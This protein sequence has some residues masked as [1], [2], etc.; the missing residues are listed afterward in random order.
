MA[1][2]LNPITSGASGTSQPSSSASRAATGASEYCG[3]GA[4]FGRPK[5]LHATTAA[6]WSR[7]HW[8]VGSAARMRRSSV[9][10]PSRTGTLKSARSRTRRPAR[11]GQ[12][13]EVRDVGGHGDRGS[14]GPAAGATGR[15]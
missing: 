15:R 14:S 5:W 8:I 2:A 6:P 10:A 11:R 4:P 13:L 12:V 3:S 7:S 9:I 1:S